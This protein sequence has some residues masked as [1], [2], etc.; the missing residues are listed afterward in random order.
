MRILNYDIISMSLHWLIAILTISLFFLGLWMVDLGYYDDWYYLGPWWH[1]GLGIVTLALVL[2][3][4]VWRIKRAAPPEISMPNWQRVS[5]KCIHHFLDFSIILIA[6]AGYF[7]VTAK[8]DGLDVFG[9]F[10]L[11]ALVTGFDA[12]ADVAGKIHLWAS[13]IVIGFAVIHA[14]A[15]LK[16]H[17]INKDSTLLQMLRLNK[18][19]IK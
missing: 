5:A 9:W 2:F 15:A 17:F 10:T 1:T 8:G 3:R 4:L 16:H 19:A 18:G 6:L 14:L 13:Y 7:I 11:P 12:Y